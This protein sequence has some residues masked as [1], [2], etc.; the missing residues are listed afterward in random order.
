MIVTIDGPAGAGKST[1]AKKLA[2]RLGFQFLDTGA[3]YRVVTWACL[4]HRVDMQNPDAVANA[5]RQVEIRFDGDRVFADGHEVT[6]E[7]R[8]IDVTH[9]SRHIAGNVEVRSHLVELQRR[10]AQGR[11]VVSEGRDQG[12]VAF[13]HAE[14]KF[15]ITAE[16][17]ERAI[18]RQRELKAR[19]EAVPLQELL[20]QIIQRDRR[21]E[22]REV[23]A[24]KP[25]PDAITIDTSVISPT[26][27]LDRLER[28]VRERMTERSRSPD[29]L[30]RP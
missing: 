3:M 21:D 11:D 25:A 4:E 30:V 22:M 10:M 14:C 8:T 28:I 1:A 6:H 12:T 5:A 15:F 23:G 9:E 19:G 2:A 13:P 27:T 26:E 7:I 16:P 29:P 17:R 20:D 24:L 18:R